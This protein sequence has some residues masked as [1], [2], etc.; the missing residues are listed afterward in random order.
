MISL[1]RAQAPV[2]N[3]GGVVNGG[4]YSEQGAEP[5]A[6][7]GSI[8]SIFGTNLASKVAVGDTIPLSSALDTVTS[9]T[10]NGV[11][12]G[13]YFVGPTQIDAQLPWDSLASG[14]TTATVNIIVT[15]NTGSS[16]SQTVNVLPAVPGIFTANQTGVG[17]AIATDSF[18]NDILAPAASIMGLTTHPFSLASIAANHAV[19]LWCTGLGA[20]SPDMPD[21][22]N[23]FNP[24]GT[25]T[26]RN[27]VLHPTVT[28]GG[29]AAT[30]V[31]SV[32]SPQF[33]S[34]YQVG[35]VPGAGTPTGNAVPVV[36][37]INGVSTLD[38]VTIAVGP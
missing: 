14:A 31:S 27:S 26:L 19:V 13:L 10:F 2:V 36:L 23:S 5:G 37:T 11:P 16:V 24:D 12:A 25:F 30:V 8:V 21:G 32:L 29:V 35:V 34:E 20:V 4:N 9:V 22:A 6:A 3:A 15:T 18:D 17:Q 28:I 38:N 33:V 7:P 1:A